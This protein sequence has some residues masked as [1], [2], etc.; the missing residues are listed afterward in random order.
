M[1]KLIYALLAFSLVTFVGCKK[2]DD[3]NEEKKATTVSNLVGSW[4]QYKVYDDED[5]WDTEYGAAYGLQ[6]TWTFNTNGRGTFV[7]IDDGIRENYPF[8]Y[9]VKSGYLY[10]NYDDGD[11]DRM[12]IKSLTQTELVLDWGADDGVYYYKRTR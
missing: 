9:E 2:D 11:T 5:G 4:E 1:K 8:E 3:K 12:K 7:V 10:V 6:V